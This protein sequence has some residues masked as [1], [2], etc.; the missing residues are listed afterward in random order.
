MGIEQQERWS[1]EINWC[2]C[3]DMKEE[4]IVTRSKAGKTRSIY[5]YGKGGD[6][7]A[8]VKSYCNHHHLPLAAITLSQT[9]KQGSPSSGAHVE[10]DE[11][12]SSS[13][14]SSPNISHMC[15]AETCWECRPRRI[16]LYSLIKPNDAVHVFTGDLPIGWALCSGPNGSLL[17]CSLQGQVTQ[18]DWDGGQ[19]GSMLT[20]VCSFRVE[21]RE[22]VRGMCYV[23]EQDSVILSDDGVKQVL[24]VRLGVTVSDHL[25]DPGVLPIVEPNWVTG[26][27]KALINGKE[28]EPEGVACDNTGR[29]YMADGSRVVILDVIDGSFIQEIQRE[30][31]GDI[32]NVGWSH[33]APQLAVLSV[34]P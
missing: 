25:S 30:G 31:D 7:V 18:Y 17:T 5:A 8:E 9:K 27:K 3:F 34:R 28:L 10:C 1:P 33:N 13:P 6:L 22:R 14:H 23:H 4:L 21:G 20:E 19:E 29:V 26:G 16:S 24:S 12:D 15:V 11:H 2:P 32:C